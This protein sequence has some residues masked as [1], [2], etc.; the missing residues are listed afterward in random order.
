M[1][2]HLGKRKIR[3]NDHELFLAS[4][5]VSEG[6][7]QVDCRC[8]SLWFFVLSEGSLAKIRSSYLIKSIRVGCSGFIY[9]W[10]LTSRLI[11]RKKL[12]RN[13]LNQLIN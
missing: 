12:I 10:Q 5:E 8:R 6:E 2:A 3:C 9:L 13:G 1:V 4:C 7:R 11:I